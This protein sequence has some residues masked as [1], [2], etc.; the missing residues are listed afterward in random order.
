M[1][2]KAKEAW[3]R[4]SQLNGRKGLSKE[5]KKERDKARHALEMCGVEA[6]DDVSGPQIRGLPQV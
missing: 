2:K 6:A 1:A 3:S 5:E 4:F